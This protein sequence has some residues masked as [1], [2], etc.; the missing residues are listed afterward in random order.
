VDFRGPDQPEGFNGFQGSDDHISMPLQSPTHWDGL[1]HVSQDDVMYN[2]YWAGNVTAYGGAGRLGIHHLKDRLVG[3]GVLLDVARHLG[4]DWLA[5]GYEITSV[6]LDACA[7]RQGVEVGPGDILLVRTGEM[8]YFY[9]LSDKADFWRAGSPGLA[10]ETVGWIHE[11]RIAALA[12]DNIAVEVVPTRPYEGSYPVHARLIRDLG[13]TIGELWWL[14]D[15]GAACADAGRWEFLLVA[16]PLPVTN[17]AGSP[18]NPIA[19]L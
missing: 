6:D 1:A 8:P 16:S 4:V 17:A 15:L 2:G 14:E 7:A 5:P 19:I 3:R 18:V 12:A 9:G 13:L 11:R 10:L